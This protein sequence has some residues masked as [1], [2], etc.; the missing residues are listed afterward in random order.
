MSFVVIAH[1][2]A[3]TGDEQ[4]VRVALE[5]MVGPSRAEPGNLLYELSVDPTD[6][7]VFAIYEKYVDEDAFRA[8]CVS[9]HFATLTEE[10][11]PHLASRVRHDLTAWEPT[12]A[13]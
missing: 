12:K 4:R 10:V 1:Y 8:H 5:R 11:L 7:A 13:R 6:P 2:R 9:A 3:R